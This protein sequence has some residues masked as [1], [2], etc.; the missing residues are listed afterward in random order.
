MIYSILLH[1]STYLFHITFQTIQR[2]SFHTIQRISTQNQ[3]GLK[4]ISMGRIF[5]ILKALT[6]S[7]QVYL[8]NYTLLGSESEHKITK[9]YT[10]DYHNY[11]KNK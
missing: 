2:I 3:L 6:G 7:R 8:I 1:F 9:K 4:Q 5:V 11:D 10:Y